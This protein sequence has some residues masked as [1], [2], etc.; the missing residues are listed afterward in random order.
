MSEYNISG[1]NVSLE[2]N[3]ASREVFFIQKRIG[4]PEPKLKL[5]RKFLNSSKEQQV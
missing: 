1:P 2:E 4:K 3:I 5:K